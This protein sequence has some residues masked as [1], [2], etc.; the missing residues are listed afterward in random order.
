MKHKILLVGIILGLMAAP[1]LSPQA[2]QKPQPWDGSRTTAVHLIPL[3]DEFDQPIVPT[4][5][6]PLPYSTRYTCAPCHDYSVIEQ[7]LHF[8]A[9][10]AS[11]HGRPGEPWVLADFQTGTVLPL[12]YHDWKGMWDPQ[13]LG[14]TFWDFTLLFGR[15]MTG[16]GMSEPEI[17]ETSPESRWNVSGR[18]EI[19]CMG[20]HNASRMQ[21]HSEWAKQVL[22][23]NFRWAGTAAS[24]LG[25][26]G[27]M[28]SRLP[29]TWDIYDGPN[30]DDTEWAVVP[31]V[32]YDRESFDSKHR[33][34]FD[35]APKIEDQRC[36]ACHS[37]TQAG[38]KRYTAAEDIHSAAG[39][40]CVDCHRNDVSHAMIR[41]YEGEDIDYQNSEVKEFSCQGCHL[42]R[43]LKK[44]GR[45]GSGRLGAPYPKHAGIPAVHFER[46]S[47]TVCHS[48]PVPAR[49]MTQVRTSRANRLGIYGVAQWSTAWPSI[50]EPVFVRER[51]GK[52]SPHRLMWPAF[53]GRMEGEK[54]LPLE[55]SLIQQA[56]GYILTVEEDVARIL[57]TIS[58]YS[59]IEGIPVLVLSGKV[60]EPN[61]DGRLDV[62]SVGDEAPSGKAIWAVKQEGKVSPIIPEFDPDAET[63][64]PDI[65]SR[66][67]MLLES[68][69]MVENPPGRPALIYRKA[70]YQITEGYLEKV[71]NPEEP[72]EKAGFVW[73]QDGRIIPMVT[74]FQVRTMTALVGYEQSL[75]EEQVKEVLKV[76]S[77]IKS[78]SGQSPNQDYFYI[79][80][81]R[82]FRL[83]AEGSLF[84]APHP[85]A[86]PV[87]WPLGHQVRPA[88]QSLGAN[89]CKDCHS[90]GSAF[91]FAGVDGVGPLKT[92]SV[93]QSSAHAFMGLSK[94]Y[95]KLFGLSFTGRPAFKVILFA[96][97]ALVGSLILIIILLALGKLSGII[98]KRR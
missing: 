51:S 91:F 75:T 26:V 23:H 32:K 38:V 15:H 12:S 31:F 63:P 85:A 6:N 43:D 11:Q 16:G 20:C 39:I 30:P 80:G 71:E 90:A 73:V 98:E 69:A 84:S 54:I 37:V 5:P 33:V 27:G 87:V 28:A 48:G 35:I 64:D 4:V 66:I 42:G 89:G 19:N 94:P 47:C 68:L 78:S 93:A 1:F 24:G 14:L 41:G 97:A 21:S 49:E 57:T 9:T 61:V 40:K 67:Q 22:R 83:D 53:W 3:K 34:F 7:G 60:Y 88:Q 74:D 8:S 17:K 96:A 52:I 29:G 50:V 18:L 25:E 62:S 65:E 95:Q 59:E 81:G 79:S 72:A 46:L 45:N 92:Q 44:K 70:L 82:M 56:A 86:E 10:A 13:E 76:L 77:Q 36:L 58:L 55:P 2:E